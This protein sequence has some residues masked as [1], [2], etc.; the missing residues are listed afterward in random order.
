MTVPATNSQPL[1]FST[2]PRP[3]RLRPAD[4]EQ[5]ERVVHLVAHADFEGREQFGREAA[6]QAVRRERAQGHPDEPGERAQREEQAIHAFSYNAPIATSARRTSS[7]PSG[8]SGAC[9]GSGAP[10]A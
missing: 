5:R 6:L 10:T 7:T 4:R 9:G 2:R 1:V 8:G 3:A